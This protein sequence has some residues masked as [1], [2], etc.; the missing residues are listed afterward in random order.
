MGTQYLCSMVFQICK[1]ICKAKQNWIPPSHHTQKTNYRWIRDLNTKITKLFEENVYKFGVAFLSKIWKPEPIKKT[2]GQI[3]YIKI[4]NSINNS[5]SKVKIQTVNVK[6]F[7]PYIR[8]PLPPG[9]R[10][11]TSC[12]EPGCTAEGEWRASER[13]FISCSP[14]LA[15]PPEP[16][17]PAPSAEKLSSMKPVPGAKK[18]G[19]RCHI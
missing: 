4:L 19:D 15:L 9:P 14:S 1:Q 8:G 13:S 6:I 5:K 7:V 12:Q 11:I 10:T 2:H 3:S 18:V 17:S 16:S